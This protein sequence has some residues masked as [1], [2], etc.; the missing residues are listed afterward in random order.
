MKQAVYSLAIISLLLTFSCR[1]DFTT[2]PSQGRLAFS[3]DTVYLDTVFTNI[4]SSTYTLKVYNTADQAV[5]IPSITLGHG[6]NSGYRLN[7]DGQP[8]KSFSNVDILAKDSLFIFIETTIDYDDIQDPLYVDDLQFDSGVNEQV[9]KLV[10]LVQDAHFLYP[11]QNAGVIE[12]L[13]I[14]GEQTEIQGRYLQDDELTFTADKPYV[15]YGYM[16][17]GD[18]QNNPKTLTMQPGTKVHFHANS[19]LIVNPN[20]SLKIL[21]ELNVEGEPE[22]EVV[23]Q[24]DRLEPSFE[25][26]PGQ[27]GVIWLREGSLNHQIS[28]ATIKNGAIGLLIDGYTDAAIPVLNVDNTQF[29][30]HAQFGI[31][32]RSTHI[33]GYNLVFNNFGFSGFAGVQGGVYEFTHCT[34]ANYWN[35]GVR[36]LPV[37]LLNNFYKDS[38]NNYTVFDLQQATFTNNIIYGNENIEL[39]LDR[40]D[41]GVFNYQFSHNLIRFSDNSGDYDDVAELDFEDTTHYTSNIINADPDFKDTSINQM[42]VGENTAGLGKALNSATAEYPIDIL[43]VTRGNPADL[44]AYEHI[45][46]E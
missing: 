2:E 40:I 16:A 31:L 7:V 4:G 41:G 23:I 1:K 17:V 13:V 9:V 33:K 24:G 6:D 10:T 39:I 37:V 14:D 19:G 25:N 45:I 8:G 11:A 18:A 34:F 36:Q 43:G 15:I 20:S 38:D 44:G 21:G 32:A 30:N 27:W 5:T 3:K 28:Y 46:F 29:Y 42:M 26:I 35:G 22:T 12:T